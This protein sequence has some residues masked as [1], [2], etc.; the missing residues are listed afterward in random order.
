MNPTDPEVVKTAAQFGLS[1]EEFI[2]R[3]AT[4]ATTDAPLVADHIDD[5]LRSMTRNSRRTYRTHLWRLRDGTGPFCDQQCEP[6][7][8]RWSGP[9]CSCPTECDVCD[10]GAGDPSCACHDPCGA[11]VA[12]RADFTC[13]CTCRPCLDSRISLAPRAQMRVGPSVYDRSAIE[14]LAS[15]AKRHAAKEGIVENR[16]RA[17]KGLAQKAAEGTGAQETAVSACRALFR[18]ALR[19]TD[20]YDG[21]DVAKPRRPGNERRPLQ[22]FELL[23]LAHETAVGGDDPSLDSLLLDYG[24]ATGARRL[25]AYGLT[26]GQLHDARQ[27]IELKDKYGRPQGAPVSAELITRLRDHS[28]S[29]RGSVCDPSSPDYLPDAPVFYYR[30]RD[31][32]RPVRS[33]RFD[34]LHKRW[35]RT[36][37]WAN[38]EQVGYHHIRHSMSMV[39]KSQ[40]GPQ[41]SKRYLRH[42]DG[43]V[44]E[45]YGACTLEELARA[46]SD[47]LEFDH[48]LVHGIED[49]RAATRRRLGYDL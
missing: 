48:P 46:M 47:L 10:D 31:G 32:V 43:D 49:R 13:R 2:A 4:P 21:H 34:T 23:E 41:Y 6:C 33:R 19:W 8:Q 36:L 15:I 39:L 27:I 3:L 44:T 5:H 26:C 35:Q 30:T 14:A 17:G 29:R 42:A 38:E 25:G 7:L 18:S 37:A 16:V 12:R 40:Y 11:C 20:G 28:I 45:L 22:D 24:I 1:P 9:A